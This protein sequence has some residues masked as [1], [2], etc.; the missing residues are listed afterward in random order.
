M[1]QVF[2]TLSACLQMDMSRFAT[3]NTQDSPCS[4]AQAKR[5]L[6]HTFQHE[7]FIS[8]KHPLLIFLA[9][10]CNELH[11][12]FPQ[13]KGCSALEAL[14]SQL[15]QALARQDVGSSFYLAGT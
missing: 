5:G 11:V 3:A 14:G 1:C 8:N 6:C 15:W 2:K 12:S 13:G 4:M 10:A 9:F 7:A